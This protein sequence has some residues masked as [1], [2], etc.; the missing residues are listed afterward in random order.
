[1]Y[2]SYLVFEWLNM[3]VVVY[4]RH[5][6]FQ[7]KRYFVKSD[8]YKAAKSRIENDIKVGIGG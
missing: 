5:G 8:P 2:G 1:M 4:H 6:L 3:P 7:T